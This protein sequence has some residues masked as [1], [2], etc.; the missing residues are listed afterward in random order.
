MDVVP[1]VLGWLLVVHATRRLGDDDKAA[2]LSLW[3]SLVA[4]VLSLADVVRVAFVSALYDLVLG[5]ALLLFFTYLA[6]LAARAEDHGASRAW[7]R[8]RTAVLVLTAAAVFL[9]VFGRIGVAVQLVLALLVAVVVT[10]VVTV[11]LLAVHSGRTWAQPG[12]GNR[13]LPDPTP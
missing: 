10:L 8:L 7:L 6:V 2:Q 4:T 1:D 9:S 12:A 5:A 13:P 3:T 11:V